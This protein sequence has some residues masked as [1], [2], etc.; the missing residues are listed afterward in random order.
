MTSYD[1]DAF[2]GLLHSFRK[3]ARLTQQQLA[4]EIGMHRHAVGRWEQGEVLP[5]SKAIVLEIARCLHLND[6]ETRL[7]IE[8][9][10]T[11]PAPLWGVPL[12]R[13]LLFAGRE[14]ILEALHAYLRLE[15]GGTAP[16]AVALHGL[17][18]VGK[19]Q[20]AL[21][22]AY[23]H[24][25][26]YAATFWINAETEES[27]LASFVAL[28]RLL[29]L[30]MQLMHKQE[31]V[32][33]LVLNWLLAHRE[34]LLIF[35]SVEDRELVARFVP[36]SRTGSLLFTTRLP[37]LGTLASSL[38]LRPL[39]REESLRLLLRRTEHQL[40]S[41]SS[42]QL[43][44][45]EERAA[46]AIA[47]AMDGLPLA[48]DQ[49]AAYIEESHCRFSDFLELFQRD[50]LQML[51][52]QAAS[53]TYPRSVE[54]TLT[55]AFERLRRQNPLAADLLI[56]CCFLAPDEIPE[57]LL[58]R[59]RCSLPCEL[60]E[61][62]A[63]P[64]R[65]NTVLRDLLAYALLHRNARTTTLTVHRL[66]QI[67][68][69]EKAPRAVQQTWTE[70]L[71]CLLDQLFVI[72]AGPG[73]YDTDRWAWC[74]R[75]LPHVFSVLQMTERFQLASCELGSLLRKIGVYL[76]QRDRYEQAEAFYLRS[77][78]VQ[79]QIM[80]GDHPDRAVTL[81][82]LARA[83][84]YRGKNQEAESLFL[85]AIAL[86]EGSVGGEDWRLTF[87]L[88]GLANFYARMSRFQEA[89]ALY[90]RVL[91][92]FAQQGEPD[93]HLVATA[94]NDLAACYYDQGHYTQAEPLLLQALALCEQVLPSHHVDIG[95]LLHNLGAFYLHWARYPEAEHFYRR[96][97]IV[98]EQAV[99]SEHTEVAVSLNSLAHLY[100][101]QARYE[102][103]E[104][105]YQRALAIVTQVNGPND[106]FGAR[107][108]NNLAILYCKQDRNEEAEKA[109][110]RALSIYGQY[111]PVAHYRRADPLHVLALVAYQQGRYSQADIFSSLAL[112]LLESALP[113]HPKL[114]AAF[115]LRANLYRVQGKNEEAKLLY[116]RALALSDRQLGATHPETM[117]LRDEYHSLLEHHK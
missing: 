8:A 40:P 102:E 97:L 89:E 39:S 7:L 112:A 100:Q 76:V 73:L 16:Q 20:T 14:E 63:D 110:T 68:F 103:A 105:L 47:A 66:V 92:I 44:A 23:R 5:T 27:L 54:K 45:E 18:G 60:Q 30:P 82:D 88:H 71:V 91:H 101:K 1:I 13:N 99:G 56:V 3:R 34:W 42:S 41:P 69:K 79:E 10:L 50:A 11:A 9:S 19:T 29:K 84:Y 74:E 94:Q 108:L 81:A 87:P 104:P 107:I 77:L 57:E 109:A 35:D 64:F 22:Y 25:L 32:V 78:S 6:A 72:K 28:A 12:P 48:L 51:Q 70:R 53:V 4:A 75:L 96:S 17:V 114:A 113:D 36:S 80:G 58:I 33:A 115:Q 31:D 21:E 116:E 55:L 52:E 37:T 83:R 49:A 38:E 111:L 2:G 86:I 43:D 106:P 59:G 15:S 95:A 62:L 24:A 85:Q 117:K 90:Q 67:I 93:Q 98:Y 26:E 65:L 61:V 46:R